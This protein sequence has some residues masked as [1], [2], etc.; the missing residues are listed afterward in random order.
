MNFIFIIINFVIFI[1]IRIFMIF[2]SF[3]LHDILLYYMSRIRA[4]FVGCN[5]LI[6]IIITIQFFKNFYFLFLEYKIVLNNITPG[7]F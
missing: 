6:I 2:R 7:S 5:V 4:F 3:C 1:L